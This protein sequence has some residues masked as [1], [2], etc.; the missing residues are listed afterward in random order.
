MQPVAQALDVLHGDKY[1]FLGYLLPAATHL[2]QVLHS[3]PVTPS[4]ANLWWKLRGGD[5]MDKTFYSLFHRTKSILSEVWIPAFK[6]TWLTSEGEQKSA[7][8]MK[9]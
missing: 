6:L 8:K 7:P 2:E 4:T 9:V 5:W 3:H 1:I